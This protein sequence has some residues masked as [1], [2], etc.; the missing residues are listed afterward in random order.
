MKY[1]YMFYQKPLKNG[2]KARYV[3]LGDPIQSYAVKL[4]YKE[5]GIREDDMLPVP[6]YD[7]ADYQGEECICVING[8]SNY[9]EMVYDSRMLPPSRTKIHAIVY[10][11]HLN[12]KLQHDELAFLK[13]SGSVGCRDIY[14]VNYLRGL[15][16]DAYLTGCLTLTLPRRS[17]AETK[18]ADKVFLID[19]PDTVRE[20]MPKEIAEAGEEHT[21]VVKFPIT[22]DGNRATVDEATAYHQ[23]SEAVIDML[24]KQARLVITSRLHITAPCLAMGI[25]VVLVLD[26]PGERFGF[27]DRLMPVYDREHYEK[28]DWHPEPVDIEAVKKTIKEDFFARIRAVNFRVEL[29]KTW[30]GMRPL[31]ELNYGNPMSIAMQKIPF[32]SKQFSY[33]VW[34]MI[35]QAPCYLDEVMKAEFP[36]AELICGIDMAA[37]QDWRYAGKKVTVCKALR[38]NLS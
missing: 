11:L 32:K 13:S 30:Q 22:H 28:I 26:Y 35:I 1:G 25:P 33:A 27:L 19:I 38:E 17:E 23:Q 2:M 7:I 6:R 12:R 29:E 14:T 36:E 21:Q 15:G 16:V 20:Y 34:G 31:T 37:E 4:L 9:E 18:G 3:N 8:S 24:R 10:S 5:M